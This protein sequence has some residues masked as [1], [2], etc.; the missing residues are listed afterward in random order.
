MSVMRAVKVKET[1]KEWFKT[2][3]FTLSSSSLN[4]L[5]AEYVKDIYRCITAKNCSRDEKGQPEA[6]VHL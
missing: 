2:V 1:Y 4:P 6:H 5:S 3:K